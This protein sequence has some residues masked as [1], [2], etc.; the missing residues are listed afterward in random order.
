[1]QTSQQVGGSIGTALLNTI[2]ATATAAFLVSNPPTGGTPEA[3][4]AAVNASDVHGFGVAF[5]WSSVIYAV[6]IPLAFVSRW[7]AVGLYV[8]VAVMWLVPDR[9]IERV[10]DP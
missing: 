7:M 1:M 9:R 5:M 8:A 3:I 10:L 6:A 4:G 2:A